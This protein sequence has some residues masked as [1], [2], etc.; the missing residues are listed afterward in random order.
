MPNEDPLL[1]RALRTLLSELIDGPAP[2]SPWVLDGRAK[3]L[4]GLLETVSAAEASRPPAPGRMTIAAHANHLRYSLELLNRWAGGEENPFATADWPGSWAV[5]EVTDE[6]WRDLRDRLAR[7]A[8]AWLA[9][10]PTPRTWDEIELTGVIG[11]VAHVAYHLGAL[12]QLQLTPA[13]C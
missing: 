3:G 8:H 13:P 11:S 7:E 5:Q 2:N 6:R 1:Y 10:A 9:A 12:R 4:L